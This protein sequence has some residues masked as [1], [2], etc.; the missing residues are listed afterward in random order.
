MNLA[1][2]NI[3][4]AYVFIVSIV[5]FLS[6]EFCYINRNDFTAMR[7]FLKSSISSHSPF[8]DRSF[9]CLIEYGPS[10]GTSWG[11]NLTVQLNSIC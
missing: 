4:I 6:S 2:Q 10:W 11:S 3:P 8:I 1:M 9:V 5:S 7:L